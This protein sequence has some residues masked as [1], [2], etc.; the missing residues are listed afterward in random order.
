MKFISMDEYF[1]GRTDMMSLPPDQIGNVNTLIPKINDLMKLY[2][3]ELRCSGGYR[4]MEDHI[5]IYK[6]KALK[7]QY[8]FLDGVYNEAKVPKGSMH[9]KAAGIDLADADGRLKKWIMSPAGQKA[10]EDLNLWIEHPDACPTW[11]HVQCIQYGS[12]I[13]GKS[14]VFRP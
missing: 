3:K 14:R 1:M 5:R 9:L 7:K 12:W 2:G 6:D 4:R 13:P 11:L 10:L 8:P